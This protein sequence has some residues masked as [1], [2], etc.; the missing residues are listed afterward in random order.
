MKTNRISASSAWKPKKVSCYQTLADVVLSLVIEI[1][2]LELITYDLEDCQKFAIRINN[3][4]RHGRFGFLKPE[5]SE[6]LLIDDKSL[7][8]F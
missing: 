6:L 8:Y 1:I 7:K 2:I 4:S 5:F 3:F